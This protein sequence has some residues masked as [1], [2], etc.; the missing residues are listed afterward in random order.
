MDETY[1]FFLLY[2]CVQLLDSHQ[3]SP[4]QGEL[5]RC[6]RSPHV[7]S[8]PQWA[9]YRAAGHNLQ[10]GGTSSGNMSK[11]STGKNRMRIAAIRMKE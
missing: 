9:Q 10:Q 7:R 11:E 3:G 4:G 2:L 1:F 5:C 8:G 6:S